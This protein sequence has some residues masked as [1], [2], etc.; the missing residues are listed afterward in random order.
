MIILYLLVGPAT[1]IIMFYL[2]YKLELTSVQASAWIVLAAGILAFVIDIN[3]EFV[4][5]VTCVS[6]AAMANKKIVC[7]YRQIACLA[8]VTTILYLLLQNTLIGIGGRLGSFAAISVFVLIGL[9]KI[10]VYSTQSRNVS[11]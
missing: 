5:I 9:A 1:G 10:T 6:Y 8:A 11:Q 4:A 7:N 3:S 2:R